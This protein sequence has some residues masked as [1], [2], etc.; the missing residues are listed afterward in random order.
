VSGDRKRSRLRL[1]LLW[2]TLPLC[3]VIAI[4]GIAAP[5][6]IANGARALTNTAFHAIDWFFI[7][8]TTGALFICLGLALSKYGAIKLGDEEPE[9]S[10]LSWLSMLFAAGMGT[11]LLFWGAA[12]PLSHY[13]GAPGV[14]P[15]TAKGAE[16]ALSI[17]A[18]HW[19]LHAWGVYGLAALVL[20][21]F[22]FRKK[23]PYL[24]S[25]PLTHTFRGKWVG[26][27][28]FGADTLAIIAVAMGVAGSVAMGTMQLETGVA[29]T[30]GTESGSQL[31][32]GI[33]LVILAVCYMASASTGLDKGIKWL[34]NINMSIAVL[35]MIFVLVAGPTSFLLRG[36]FSLVGDYVSNL[37]SM[38]LHLYPFEDARGWVSG[39]TLTYFTWWIAW[40]PFVG[41][42]IARISRGRTIREFVLG[43]LFAPTAF[44]LLWFSIFG[45]T[46]IHEEMGGAGLISAVRE[47]VTTA[48]FVLF[49]SLPMSQILSVTALVLLFI[50]LVTSVDSATFVLGMM[51]SKGSLNPSAKRKLAWG[52]ALGGLAGALMFS[53]SIDVVKAL[54]IVGAIPFTF[55]L[56]LQASALLRSL[57]AEGRAGL[58]GKSDGAEK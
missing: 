50:F 45:G 58:F 22:G 48:L 33:I 11:G 27:L 54:A 46:G 41:V 16:R 31:V 44:S 28:G 47:D 10:T 26:P 51:T 29:I 1:D 19:G 42:F 12:E 14:E 20:S 37:V 43:V 15:G 57:F 24:P 52:I 36:F 32:Q 18:L 35:L 34:S 2:V 40:A 56:L 39:W 5:E 4:L 9:F 7:A 53:R 3:L 30:G 25:A 49:E 13:A 8:A 55:I 23:T 6:T 21:Y 38:S 17:T